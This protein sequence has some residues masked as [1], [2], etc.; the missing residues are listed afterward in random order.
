MPFQFFRWYYGDG[1]RRTAV[2]SV[3]LAIG[4]FKYFSVRELT[5]TI[6]SPWHRIT[7]GY[8]RGFD[9]STFFFILGGNIISR[10]L[11]AI[12][13]VIV[14]VVGIIVSAGAALLGALGIVLWPLLPLAI[15]AAFVSGLILVGF[16]L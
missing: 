9:P 14:I 2:L 16:S 10:I 1:F 7:E 6:F 11:G 5:R 13:R 4:C 15:P 12:V 8:G 3:N